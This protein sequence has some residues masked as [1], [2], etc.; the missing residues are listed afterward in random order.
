MNLLYDYKRYIILY[1]DDEEMSLKYFKSNFE[2]KFNILVANSAA[3]ALLLFEKHK[4]EI[5]IL[6]TDQRMPSGTGV[7]LLEKVRQQRPKIIKILATAYSDIDAAVA[8]VNT[9]SIYKYISKPWD[10]RDLEVTL[11]RAMEFFIIQGER[12]ALLREKLSALH[13]MMMTDR[14]ISLGLLAS[15]LSHHLRNALVAVRVFLDLA[16]LKLESEIAN[17]Q[18]LKNPDYW[19]EFYKTVQSQMIKT[20][21]ILD[22]LGSIPSTPP[23]HFNDR[24]KISD[25]IRHVA[26]DKKDL[27]GWNNRTVQFKCSETESLLH[28]DKKMFLRMIDSLLENLSDAIPPGSALNIAITDDSQNRQV[29]VEFSAAGLKLPEES[30]KHFFDPFYVQ[31]A[32]PRDAGINLLICYFI[33]YHHGGQFSI[34]VTENGEALY[35]IIMPHDPSLTIVSKD[36][37]Q[38]LNKVFATESAWERLLIS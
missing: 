12:D 4:D 19:L 28:V 5:A 32:N 24:V 8:A 15:G 10:S 2:D 22:G 9:G 23:A 33:V 27:P 38:F 3:E 31:D 11:M 36:E 34:S 20:T 29:K 1:V 35:T 7:Q 25:M 13:R 37:E 16:P 30:L 6:M 26:Q 18:H 14:L 21:G 17:I